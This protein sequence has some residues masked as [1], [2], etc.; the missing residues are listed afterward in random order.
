M[1]NA[2]AEVIQ[3]LNPAIECT[4]TLHLWVFRAAFYYIK[5][6]L[7]NYCK[8]LCDMRKLRSHAAERKGNNR[9]FFSFQHIIG[10]EPDF[11]RNNN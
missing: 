1:N 10:L 2:D 5:L 4:H 11:R 3:L 7:L 6:K 8:C 9:F